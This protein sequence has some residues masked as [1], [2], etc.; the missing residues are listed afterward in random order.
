[1]G[2]EGTHRDQLLWAIEGDESGAVRMAYYTS[3][4]TLETTLITS[5][6]SLRQLTDEERVKLLK[7]FYEYLSSLDC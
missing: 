5:V 2:T 3:P 7:P 1:M 6:E 4:D